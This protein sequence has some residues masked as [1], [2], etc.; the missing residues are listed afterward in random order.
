MLTS[1]QLVVSNINFID[2]VVISS[3]LQYLPRLTSLKLSIIHGHFYDSKSLE[4][5]K[6]HDL[7]KT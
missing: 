5:K 6:E 4:Y 1:L 2:V 7:L 3:A